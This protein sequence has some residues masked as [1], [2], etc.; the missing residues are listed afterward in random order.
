M[1]I[2]SWL[3]GLGFG[4]YAQAFAANDIDWALLV[5]LSDADLKELGVASLGHRKRLLAAIAE[6]TAE[7]RE[8]LDTES[9]SDER[10]Q[11][12]I[13]FADL[14][15]FTA[16][17]HALDPE[18]VRDLVS[19]YTVLVDQI[20]IGYGGTIDKHIG[21]AVMALFGA[22]RAH[23]DDALRAARAAID[24]HEALGRWSKTAG[25]RLSAHVGIAGGE[26]VAG[27]LARGENQD[28]TVLGSSV[29]LAA[30]LVAAAAPGETLITDGVSVALAERCLC[31]GLGER[32]FK[33]ID[34]LVRVWRLKA[35]A[36]ETAPTTRTPFVGR[37]AELEHFSSIVRA[38]LKRQTGQVI[39]VRGEAGIGKTRLVEEMRRLAEAEGF[40]THR[41]LTLDFGMGR[42]QDPIRAIVRSLLGVSLVATEEE[43]RTAA[44]RSLTHG[45]IAAEKLAFL[46]DMLDLPPSGEWRGLYDAMDNGAR[47]RGKREVV[48]GLV[49]KACDRGPVLIIVEDL[50]WAD[51]LLLS[52][53]SP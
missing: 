40:V 23:D 41:G 5:E 35:L 17:S 29:N 27:S 46:E 6:R 48:A 24:I 7:L 19:R 10:R 44:A 1:D 32:T 4:Q 13:L 37:E 3:A 42:G 51:P 43:R 47:N 53:W 26:V 33:G 8:P 45:L 15:G 52:H 25:Q 16:L 14:T 12:T 20:V 2:G 49:A 18:E 38:C 30:R 31:E 39:Y 21:D 36:S 34:A 50:H 22:P 9:L 11:V 28:Y